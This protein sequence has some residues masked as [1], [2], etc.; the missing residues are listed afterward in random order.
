MA[1]LSRTEILRLSFSFAHFR[2]IAYVNSMFRN[3]NVHSLFC[4]NLQTQS[5]NISQARNSLSTL[6]F[7]P[8]NLLLICQAIFLFQYLF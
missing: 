3:I 1:Y 5:T 4:V 7:E 2:V 8:C 6:N